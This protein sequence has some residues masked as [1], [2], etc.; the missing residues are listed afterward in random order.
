MGKDIWFRNIGKDTSY[1]L[2]IFNTHFYPRYSV[3][4]SQDVAVSW[5]KNHNK[6][7]HFL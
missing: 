1:E 3:D 2:C 5:K 7:S 6:L 4:F